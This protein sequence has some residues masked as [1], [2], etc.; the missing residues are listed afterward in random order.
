M[1]RQQ[2]VSTE[3][4]IQSPV[5]L[6]RKSSSRTNPAFRKSEGSRLCEAAALQRNRAESESGEV[7]PVPS[8]LPPLSTVGQVDDSIR[9]RASKSDTSLTDSFVMVSDSDV[10]EG[11]SMPR[12]TREETIAH[13]RRR[14]PQNILREG[15]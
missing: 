6:R 7:V 11:T 14:N 4:P 2:A 5:I 15:Q 3:S 13:Q 10:M 1:H 12:S 8:V 9:I